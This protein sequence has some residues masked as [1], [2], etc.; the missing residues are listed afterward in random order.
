MTAAIDRKSDRNDRCN[1]LVTSI[2]N[3][4]PLLNAIRT[5]IQ[6]LAPDQLLY[7]ADCNGLCIAHHFVDHF[8]P[9]P[10]DEELTAA[11]VLEHCKARSIR[12]IIPTRDEELPLYAAWR[13]ELQSAGIH[14]M[15]SAPD[16]VNS[17]RDKL[18]FA[19]KIDEITP[20]SAIATSQHIDGIQATDYV[21]KE[22]FGSGGQNILLGGSYLEALTWAERLSDP[23]FQPYIAGHE[24]SIDIFLTALSQTK[25]V[26]VR[27]RDLIVGGEAQI[28]TTICEPTIA[29]C[30]SEVAEHLQLTGHVIF[31]G[32]KTP[33]GVFKLIECNCRF[34]GASTLSIAAGLDSFFWFLSEIQGID[35]NNI[36]FTP[37]T[38]QLRQIRHST[39]KIIHLPGSAK[40]T[41]VL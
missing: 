37:A 34:G 41:S 29:S 30:C 15:V 7:G 32:I 14:V 23:L 9:F 13:Q 25:G 27:S 20:G 28:S 12:A 11:I 36:P 16:A 3:K 18:S 4:V 2:G 31:Q 19:K 5:A 39:D 21:V 8:I 10:R 6:R 1:V 22:R 38:G 40:S 33:S 17:C 26:V 35:L 24:V